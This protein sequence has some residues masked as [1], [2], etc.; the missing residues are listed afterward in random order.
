MSDIVCPIEKADCPICGGARNCY[1]RASHT[2]CNDYGD[3]PLDDQLVGSVMQCCGCEK[4]FYREKYWFSE[5]THV[6]RDPET[7]LDNLEP[8]EHVK[9]WPPISARDRPEWLDYT[10]GVDSQL[11]ALLSELYL[12]LD[13]GLLIMTG[14]AIR[15]CIDRAT[16]LVEVD[17]ILGFDK[18]LKALFDDGRIGGT[19]RDILATLI[20]AGSAAAHRGWQPTDVEIGT[21]MDVLEQFLHRTFFLREESERIRERVPPRPKRAR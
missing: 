15:T 9:F 4:V 11:H 14:I 20:D 5:D 12:G 18:K 1:V 10:R 3:M 19:E 17:P 21:M 16:E 8:V 7:G 6:T 13:N 2:H